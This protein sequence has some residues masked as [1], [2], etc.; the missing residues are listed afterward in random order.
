MASIAVAARARKK[1]RAA[2]PSGL[3]HSRQGAGQGQPPDSREVPVPGI[4]SGFPV[5]R[6]KVC[7]SQKWP[8]LAERVLF[9]QFPRP[10]GLS[11]MED[12][13]ELPEGLSIPSVFVPS[14][15]MS[16][17]QTERK[18]TFT[19]A[20]HKASG[21]RPAIQFSEPQVAMHMSFL[22]PLSPLILTFLFFCSLSSWPINVLI[23]SADQQPCF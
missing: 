21:W 4:L 17:I 13:T 5:E 11:C 9:S 7:P 2:F 23:P 12:A 19:E 8:L 1:K 22:S 3:L 14:S 15:A 16:R 6:R 20:Y 10:H 18:F